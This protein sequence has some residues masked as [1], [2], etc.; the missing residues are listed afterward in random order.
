M[1]LNLRSVE[2]FRATRD[3]PAPLAD[4]AESV[5]SI[6]TQLRDGADLAPEQ[7]EQV[8]AHIVDP[9]ADPLLKGELLK[10]LRNKGES[11]SEIAG[12]VEALL[13]RAIDPMLDPGR[14]SGPL[15][16]VCGTGGDRM[17]LFNVST[18]SMFLLAAGGAVVV[19]HG[20][21]AITSKS[22]GA[23]VLEALGVRIQLS[24]AQ[25]RECVER[26]GLGFIFAPA[27]HPAFQQ[28][29]PVRK[30][31][32]AEGVT[33]IFNLLG[34]LLNPA[35]P[36][37][38]LA[39]IFDPQLLSKYAGSL[40]ALNRRHAW[41]VHG[42]GIDELSISDTSDIAEVKAS[43]AVRLFSFHPAELAI[44][45]APLS[46]LLGGDRD[47]NAALLRG[48]LSGE[49]K[50]AKRDM[51]LLNAAAGFLVAGLAFDLR[52]GWSLAVEQLDSGRALGKLEA[53]QRFSAA[54]LE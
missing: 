29:G 27:F 31:L 18:T 26:H 3:N 45:P 42:A 14:L 39:G 32:A 46:E 44:T 2:L 4:P 13:R 51:V 16:D 6:L 34:P 37:H 38:Q 23:D 22:G 19:K 12:F 10:A 33:T 1:I 53:L 52:Q 30:A 35:R 5:R 47:V 41:A 28:I 25:L 11:A 17:D 48:I 8:V 40:A 9:R 49:V 43:A 15:I 20:N 50:G 21:R 36:P 7:I 24:P 54:I